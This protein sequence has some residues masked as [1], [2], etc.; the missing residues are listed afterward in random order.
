MSTTT[1]TGPTNGVQRRSSR[2]ASGARRGRPGPG[3]WFGIEVASG[4]AGD[5]SPHLDEAL[6]F[7]RELRATLA[8]GETVRN[9]A[10]DHLALRMRED[11][12]LGER[13][14]KGQRDAGDVANGK[15]VGDPRLERMPGCTTGGTRCGGT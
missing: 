7:P 13:F 5:T 1:T 2:G 15:H 11:S 8:P 4:E 14:P 10:S 6:S 12:C 9:D 3:G